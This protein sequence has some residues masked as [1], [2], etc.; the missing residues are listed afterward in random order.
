MGADLP[1]QILDAD[2]H[3]VEPPTL[4]QDH[5]DPSKRALAITYAKDDHGRP[6]HRFAGKPS[7]F[8]VEGFGEGITE[9]QKEQGLDVAVEDESFRLPGRLLSRLNPL[10]GLSEEEKREVVAQFR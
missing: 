3:F 8:T 9:M 4:Y 7:K 5:I 6:V 10:K 1:Y 2:N